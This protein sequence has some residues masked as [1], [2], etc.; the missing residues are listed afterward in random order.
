MKVEPDPIPDEKAT[1]PN[2]FWKVP[3]L[4][5]DEECFILG[6]GPGLQLVDVN[7]L[8]GRCVIA[9]NMAFTLADW[10]PAMYFADHRLFKRIGPDLANFGG[11]KMTT[12]K[13][14]MGTPGLKIVRQKNGVGISRDPSIV[15]WNKS[16]GACAIN[17][18]VHFGVR[19]IVL[20]GY[21]MR[22][23][24]APKLRVEQRGEGWFVVNPYSGQDVYDKPLPRDEAETMALKT[25]ANWHEHYPKPTGKTFNPYPRFLDPFKKIA[26][27]LHGLNIECVN[28][29]PGSALTEFPI[30]HP[31][32]VL[33]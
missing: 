19:R 15:W 21:D 8:K 17:I 12:A 5:P 22:K 31:A 30:V 27:D 20:L 13:G 28:A 23:A 29:T 16:S 26:Y 18:A 9:I 11:L 2:S 14:L 1:T 33:P 4:W 3:R 24:E 25:K 10:L 6:G 32:E 7:R